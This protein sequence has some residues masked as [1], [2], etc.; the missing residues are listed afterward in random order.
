MS[1]FTTILVTGARGKTGREVAARLAERTGIAVRGG[2]SDPARVDE[3]GVGPVAFDWGRP[4]TWA[5][6]LAGAD[7]VYL[8]RP[9]IQDAPERVA[10]VVSVAPR[11]ARIVL[12]SEM[13]AEERPM[14]G[15]ALEVERAVTEGERPWTI[16]RPSWFQQV[17]TD[18]RFFRGPIAESGVL[19]M[20]TG[21]GAAISYVDAGDIAAVA[22]EA[23]TA[24]GH[25]GRIHTISG[26]AALEA[27]EVARLLSARLGRPV[28]AVDPSPEDLVAGLDPW[29]ADL[30]T[31]VDARVRAGGFRAV[32]DTVARVTGRAARTVEEFVD[33]HA[34]AWQEA[35]RD[36]GVRA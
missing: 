11:A 26:P 33:A 18:E 29:T 12:L 10:E 19:P 23:L 30:F 6:A 2:S 35:A 4:A 31:D 28:G 8:M 14:G 24:P 5:D 16:L 32:T 27:G 9:D 13:G 1:A 7:A 22:V 25:D 20:P 34:E 15:W 17:L 3:P 36:Q 21:A